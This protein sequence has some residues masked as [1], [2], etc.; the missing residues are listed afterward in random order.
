LELH[1]WLADLKGGPVVVWIPTATI[2]S[3]QKSELVLIQIVIIFIDRDE[4]VVV[5]ELFDGW[6]V[7][8]LLKV[9]EWHV[10]IRESEG[11]FL[12]YKWINLLSANVSDCCFFF[13]LDFI[14][15]LVDSLLRLFRGVS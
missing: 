13:L 15:L 2:C 11:E 3:V 8:V 10:R 4:V 6:E 9:P 7:S 5:A 12:S 1:L 14:A